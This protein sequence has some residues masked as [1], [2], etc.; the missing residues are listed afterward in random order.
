MRPCITQRKR[1]ANAVHSAVQTYTDSDGFQHCRL[2]CLTGWLL[3][4]GM[5]YERT[6]MQAGRLVIAPDKD[7]ETNCFEMN[8]EYG[9][10]GEIH[11]WLALPDQQLE[12]GRHHLGENVQ[13]IDFW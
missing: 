3:L 8:P 10:L 2:Y 4:L 6:V 11:C 13:L 9:V 12:P 1:I 5:G 7:D